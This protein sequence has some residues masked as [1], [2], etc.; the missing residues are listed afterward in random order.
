MAGSAP[1]LLPEM[2]HEAIR[3][4]LGDRNMRSDL[5]ALVADTAKDLAKEQSL[6]L[7]VPPSITV[8]VDSILGAGSDLSGE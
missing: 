5:A 2:F 8:L 4:Y 3:A 7:Y 1:G 6:S